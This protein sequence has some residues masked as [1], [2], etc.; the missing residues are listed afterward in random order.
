MSLAGVQASTRRYRGFMSDS[1]RWN[2]F[3]L[4]SDDVIISTPSKCGTTWM[5][6]I[7]G[8][9]LFN[10]VDLGGPLSTVSPWLDMLIHSEEETFGQ[11]HEQTHRRFIKTHTPLDG[12]PYADSVTYITVTRH[13]LDVAM[14]DLDHA[15]NMRMEET[16]QLRN[17]VSGKYDE[18]G[19]PQ[20]DGPDD[21]AEFLRWFIAN[22]NEPNGSGPHGLADY[23]NQVSTYWAA[24]YADNVHLFHYADM[25]QDL[26]GQMRRVAAALRVG[27]DEQMFPALVEAASLPAMRSRA[28]STA[29][30]AHMKLWK[31]PQQF[32]HVGG[33][34]DWAAL[35]TPADL[36]HFHGRLDQ[37]L[38]GA[39]IW[40]Q[41]GSLTSSTSPHPR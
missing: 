10:L 4:R 6:T 9:L 26:D 25:W 13:P 41:H 33:T 7:V 34:R 39:A 38:G 31:S 30:E 37:L 32:F 23:C 20:E 1:D 17:A 36:N 3:E 18:S 16:E 22:G 2:R 15:A 19:S 28:E 8:M 24:R 5:Q 21:P 11:L 35:L 14:S 40:A 12:L 27:V 29:P